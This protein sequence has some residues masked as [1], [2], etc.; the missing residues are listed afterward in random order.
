MKM[1]KDSIQLNRY[2]LSVSDLPGGFTL[3]GAV[4][5]I[6]PGLEEVRLRL[7]AESP[8]PPAP[9]TVEWSHPLVMSHHVWNTAAKDNRRM[10]CWPNESFIS[11][12]ACS[13]APVYSVYSRDGTNAI[14]FA[15]SDALN[16]SELGF[17]VIEESA[18]ARCFIRFWSEPL[19]PMTDYEVTLRFDTRE[20]P[21]YRSL[22]E[23]SDWW[24]DMPENRP[25]PVPE[26]ARCPMYSTWYSFHQ[27]MTAD[28]LEEQCRLAKAMGME[29]L[30]V[31]DGWQ[32]NDNNRGYSHCGD[33]EIAERK[34]PDMAAHVQR[35]H[36]IG[37][38][39][40]M[41]F[42]VPFIG[43]RS[44]AYER[45][46]GKYLDDDDPKRF[47]YV[48]D[49]R[50]PEVREY[51]IST[52]EQFVR[53]Y[54]IDGFKLDF[55]D[56]FRN[57]DYAAQLCG[58]GRDI[59]SVPVAVDRLLTD[60]TEHLQR[61]KPD[62]LI[63]FRQSYI[64]PLMRKYGNMFRANDVPADFTGNRIETLDIRQ[65]CGNTA[66]HADMTLWHAGDTVESAAMQLIHTLFSVPQISV[67]LDS[68]PESHLDMLKS[69]LAFWQRHRDVLLDGELMPEH[70]EHLYTAVQA[71]TET[72]YLAV[73][74]G[75]RLLKIDSDLP[76]L[77]IVVN[78]TL[79][80][81][82]ILELAVDIGPRNV[83][84]MDCTGHTVDT[85][86]LLPFPVGLHRLKIPPAGH[87]L[88][89]LTS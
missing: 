6:E 38:K 43:I 72:K 16:V 9:F 61:L 35:V 62:I 84:I 66:C 15:H 64:G 77:L 1:H 79:R 46:K 29:A 50:F 21:W 41:W 88:L 31:D 10:L 5:E 19:P 26:S 28:A 59:A 52:Y 56:S 45:F 78:G 71:R 67:R 86:S 11:S 65:L 68:L 54:D 49:P 27:P 12:K 23:V 30:I 63:E 51:L 2:T 82:L 17:Q 89:Y 80:P 7:S 36:E 14:T 69:Y 40:V 53:R 87:V 37:M 76:E 3:W 85:G 81:D 48:L 33:W 13:E 4:E 58:D 20:I 25:M 83:Q 34:F 74:Y 42:S 70:P 39:Y 75:T 18:C 60:V 57:S 22:R 44:K 55:V 8:T 32:T 24:A 47:W 73:A